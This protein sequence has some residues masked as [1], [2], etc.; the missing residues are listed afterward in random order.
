MVLKIHGLAL[1]TTGNRRNT[2]L[3]VLAQVRLHVRKDRDIGRHSL[4]AN[5]RDF[6]QESPNWVQVRLR[7]PPTHT[8]CVRVRSSTLSRPFVCFS[9]PGSCLGQD[10]C[11][12]IAALLS[13]A[14]GVDPADSATCTSASPLIRT[15]SGS[16]SGLAQFVAARGLGTLQEWCEEGYKAVARIDKDIS[17]V[18]K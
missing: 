1:Q 17:G 7:R 13:C 15:H 18:M 3:Y 14:V 6:V 9:C 10:S 12:N 8:T 4:G 5:K 11:S 16:M 2:S